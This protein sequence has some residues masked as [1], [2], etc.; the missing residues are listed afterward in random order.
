MERSPGWAVPCLAGAQSIPW[1]PDGGCG[2]GR[3]AEAGWTLPARAWSRVSARPGGQASGAGTW[4]GRETLVPLPSQGLSR[5]LSSCPATKEGPS[6]TAPT[7]RARTGHPRPSALL[8]GPAGTGMTGG[9][10]VVWAQPPW[11]RPARRPSGLGAARSLGPQLL[12]GPGRPGPRP[13]H[14]RHLQKVTGLGAPMLG[15]GAGRC[16]FCW[17]HL[18]K[19]LPSGSSSG[20]GWLTGLVP[21]LTIL[22]GGQGVLGR[23]ALLSLPGAS[24]GGAGPARGGPQVTGQA[25]TEAQRT[26]S[27]AQTGRG[28]HSGPGLRAAGRKDPWG[29]PARG[30]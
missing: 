4:R 23:G 1:E 11:M 27:A 8:S 2:A 6:Q 19:R 20:Q 14:G 13:H 22:S 12:P 18:A 15:G 30:A 29:R 24:G 9:L 16:S 3:G 5:V 25:H 28:A 21:L 26:G 7:W 10:T 17:K